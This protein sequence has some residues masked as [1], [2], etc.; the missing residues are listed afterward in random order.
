MV[1][2]IK[3]N[4]QFRLCLDPRNLN[5]AIKRP[6]HCLP[7]TD[8]IRSQLKNSKYFTKLDITSGFWNLQFD[9]ESANFYNL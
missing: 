1:L 2:A 4:K 8:I 5:K 3:K 7:N 6:Q 9:E